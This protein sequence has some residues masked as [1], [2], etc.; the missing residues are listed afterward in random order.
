MGFINPNVGIGWGSIGEP[1]ATQSLEVKHRPIG[2]TKWEYVLSSK[3][4]ECE[5]TF[6][7]PSARGMPGSAIEMIIENGIDSFD[8]KV[9]RR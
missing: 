4:F 5:A 6:L 9:G 2:T 8:C 3:T 1:P 7:V